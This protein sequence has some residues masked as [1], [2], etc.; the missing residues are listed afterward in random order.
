MNKSNKTSKSS[1]FG[2]S[3]KGALD[4]VLPTLFVIVLV[5]L[6]MPVLSYS[7][8][9]L[10]KETIIPKYDCLVVM[11]DGSRMRHSFQVGQGVTYRNEYDPNDETVPMK[12]CHFSWWLYYKPASGE[13]YPLDP[14]VRD[15]IPYVEFDAV[16]PDR[17]HSL[18]YR[19]HK[20]ICV[21]VGD[22]LVLEAYTDAVSDYYTAVYR[23]E[24]GSWIEVKKNDVSTSSFNEDVTSITEYVVQSTD[25]CLKIVTH[26]DM[27]EDSRHKQNKEEMEIFA[28][29]GEL[30]DYMT[31][32]QY[33]F[34]L[35]SII[36]MVIVL[37]ASLLLIRSRRLKR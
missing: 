34:R 4:R 22:T 2:N 10:E 13:L 23:E 11:E 36:G 19:L 5:S 26:Y 17:A 35:G 9:V 7:T 32:E 29:V 14:L 30:P 28:Y 8:E 33:R 37:C 31:Y 15:D 24:N 16:L 21:Q 1:M 20:I 27:K 12:N 25:A 6:V 18:K 3:R